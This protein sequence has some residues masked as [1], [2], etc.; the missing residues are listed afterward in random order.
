M[1]HKHSESTAQVSAVATQGQLLQAKDAQD[2]SKKSNY[3]QIFSRVAAT[4]AGKAV[5][6]PNTRPQNCRTVKT[7]VFSLI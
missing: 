2:T 1:L 6:G 5:K 7:L 3:Q 4:A